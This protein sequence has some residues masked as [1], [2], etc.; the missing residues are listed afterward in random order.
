M[1]NPCTEGFTLV[2]V[3]VAVLVLAIGLLGMAGLQAV[4]LKNNNTA[5]LRSQATFLAYELADRM[6]ANNATG[7]EFYGTVTGTEANPN[8]DCTAAP[9]TEQDMAK[10]DIYQWLQSL[11]SSLPMGIGTVTKAG[12]V[13]TIT[14]KWDDNRDGVV[15]N[16]TEADPCFVLSVQP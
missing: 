8:N 15:E 13:H 7:N 3:L 4:G 9:C 5:Y 14:I 10:S 12:A 6:R 2:E 1:K 16:C 11:Q